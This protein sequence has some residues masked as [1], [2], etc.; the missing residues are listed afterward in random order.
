MR[1][2]FC[3]NFDSG[4][5]DKRAVKGSGQI[6]RRRQCLRC[7]ERFTTYEKIA[8]IELMVVKRDGKKEPF[9]ID[10]V[11]VGVAKALEKRPGIDKIEEL[12]DK[13]ERRI[14]SQ[15]KKEVTS[16]VI[17]KIVLSELKKLDKVA[18][19]RFASVYR[20]FEDPKDFARELKSL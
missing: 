11:K 8:P 1:C 19:L 9:V 5:I 15:G 7:Q 10:K 13:I 18:Y 17:G 2:P 12:I 3:G 20:Q 6:R 16:S 4:V 14:R